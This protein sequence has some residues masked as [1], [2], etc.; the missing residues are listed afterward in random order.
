CRETA[1]AAIAKRI[2]KR[3]AFCYTRVYLKTPQYCSILPKSASAALQSLAFHKGVRRS[4]ALQL[5]LFGELFSIFEFSDTPQTQ[6]TQGGRACKSLRKNPGP[7]G[8]STSFSP[9]C[10]IPFTL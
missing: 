1:F 8:R 2:A 4:C 3:R 6:N 5:H 9:G 10:P 7:G